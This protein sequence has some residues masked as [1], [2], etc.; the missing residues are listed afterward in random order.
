MQW[1]KYSFVVVCALTFYFANRS[2]STFKFDLYS[3]EFAVS[4][5]LEIEKYFLY[6]KPAMGH[7][8]GNGPAGPLCL[9]PSLHAAQP[10]AQQP[11]LFCFP[12]W[13]NVAACC[14]PSCHGPV[15]P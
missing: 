9:A 13:L 1:H 7:I 11:T 15:S 10:L 4:K 12:V 14:Q 3:N 2:R 5:I 8:F 6:S